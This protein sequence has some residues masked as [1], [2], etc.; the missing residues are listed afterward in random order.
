MKNIQWFIMILSALLVLSACGDNGNQ[1][2]SHNDMRS[3]TPPKQVILDVELTVNPDVLQPGDS[4]ELQA[5]VKLEGE[6]VEDA[7]EVRFEVWKH[8]EE[9]HEMIEG[10][11]LGEGVYGISYT[12]EEEAHYYAVSHVTARDTHRMPKKAITVGSPAPMDEGQE[13]ESH[14][15]E[16]MHHDDMMHDDDTHHNH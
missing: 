11:H 3:T 7:D 2:N 10:Q 14:M 16:D 5:S 13:E 9:D 1:E 12:F 8:G 15:D 4:A 6:A